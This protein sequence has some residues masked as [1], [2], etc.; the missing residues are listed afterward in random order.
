VEE[1]LGKNTTKWLR[2]GTYMA[3][4]AGCVLTVNV[5]ISAGRYM[6]NNFYGNIGRANTDVIDVATSALDSPDKVEHGDYF[7]FADLR[8]TG[9]KTFK[10][11]YVIKTVPMENGMDAE[12]RVLDLGKWE[13]ISGTRGPP[14]GAGRED[15]MMTTYPYLDENGKRAVEQYFDGG[16][17]KFPDIPVSWIEDY[18]RGVPGVPDHR[19]G[20]ISKITTRNKYI[21]NKTYSKR[22]NHIKER[23]RRHQNR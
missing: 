1:M 22:I 7:D 11:K 19:V 12:I 8:G 10:G 14:D 18:W 2:S 21:L 3:G 17:D 5:L 13:P 23:L 20:E 4:I 16:L 6:S 15:F 9:N